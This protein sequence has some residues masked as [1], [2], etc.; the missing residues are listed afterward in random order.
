LNDEYG[1]FRAEGSARPRGQCS[2]YRVFRIPDDDGHREA[3]LR[4]EGG[5]GEGGQGL[6]CVF[7]LRRVGLEHAVGKASQIATA[8]NRTRAKQAHHRQTR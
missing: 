8:C 4:G 3:A 5:A 6:W 2:S 7:Q 1:I